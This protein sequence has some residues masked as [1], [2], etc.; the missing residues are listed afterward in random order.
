MVR[1]QACEAQMR[2][3]A[4]QAFDACDLDKNGWIEALEVA[5]LVDILTGKPL[6]DPED[7]VHG[8]GA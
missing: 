7:L 3:L 2:K 6:E 8:W 4:K 1:Y 5:H